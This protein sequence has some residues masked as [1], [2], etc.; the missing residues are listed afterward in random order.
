MVVV[1]YTPARNDENIILDAR[2]LYNLDHVLF[3][4]DERDHQLGVPLWHHP[5]NLQYPSINH[6]KYPQQRHYAGCSWSVRTTSR[7]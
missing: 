7:V 2:A 3:T 6:V 1:V 4:N 5:H